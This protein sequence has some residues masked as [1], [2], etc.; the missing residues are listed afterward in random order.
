MMTLKISGQNNTPLLPFVDSSNFK[1]YDELKEKL[2]RVIMG[3]R[4]TEA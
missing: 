3:Q 1:T 2:N 4:N